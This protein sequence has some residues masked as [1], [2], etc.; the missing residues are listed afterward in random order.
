MKSSL[1]LRRSVLLLLSFFLFNS[2]SCLAAICTATNG[3]WGVAATWSCGRLPAS[4]DTIDIPAGITVSVVNAYPSNNSSY[5][6]TFYLRISGTLSF[7]DNAAKIS[8]DGSGKL[9]IY[10]GGKIVTTISNASAWLKIGNYEVF[11]SNDVLLEGPRFCTALGCNVSLPISLL[12]FQPLYQPAQG[13]VRLEW[14]TASE[15]NNDYFTVERSADAESFEGIE[16]VS[17][18]GNSKEQR[19]YTTY[20]ESPLPGLSY[21]RLRQTDFDGTSTVSKLMA[22][23]NIGTKGQFGFEVAPNPFDGLNLSL[24]LSGETAGEASVTVFGSLGQKYYDQLQPIEGSQLSMRLNQPLARG[25]YWVKVSLA[26][27]TATQAVLVTH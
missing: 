15:I 12:S 23:H 11:R 24:L 14:I 9:D 17:G 27:Q 10:Q 21:Y 5:A 4:G 22:V 6:N 25:L 7:N 19:A 20:D 1:R 8:L 13:R 18:A 2:I 3:E 26:G 16:Q